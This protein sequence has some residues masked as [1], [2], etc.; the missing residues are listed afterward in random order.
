MLDPYGGSGVTLIEAMMLDRKA[1]HIDLNPLSVFLVE[2]LTAP[3][4]VTDL[5]EAF[6]R[7]CNSFEKKRPKSE[8]QIKAALEKYWYPKGIPLTKDAD[9]ETIEELFTDQQLAGLALLRNLIMKEK[10]ENIKNSLLLSFSSTVTKINRTYHSSSSRGENA[11]NA[12]AFA[13]YRYRMA[14]EEVRLLTLESFKIKFKKLV[15]AKKDISSKINRETIANATIVRGDATDLSDIADQ[16]IDYIYTDPPYGSKIAYLDLSTMWNAWLGFE[17]TAEDYQKEAIEGGSLNKSSDE[18]GDLLSK[19]IEEMFRVLKFDRWMSFVFAHK[20]PQY[21]HLIVETAEKAGFEYAGAV[22][23]SNGQ[24]SFKKR[25]NPFSVLSGQLVINFKKARN[26]QTIQKVRLGSE[27]YDLIIETIESVIAQDDGATLEQINDELILKGLELGFLDVLSKEYKDLTPILL[28]HFDY[29]EETD[30]FHIHVDKKFK[31][32]IPLDLRIRY[33]LLSYL[34][35][36][37]KERIFPTTDEI[38]LDIMPLLKNGITP[39]NQTILKVLGRIGEHHG[40]ERWK[41]KKTGQASL[42]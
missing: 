33:F 17:I 16:S 10:N 41:I 38:I 5:T 6:D 8:K 18:Y 37:E 4:S 2:A 7:V 23:Q 24:T 19:S 14:K 31:T 20:D 1:I 40:D 32:N 13:Y 3:V 29:H 30:T 12:A 26:Q 42:F 22:K 35:R 28:D 34:R 36:K 15:S 27:I 25:Q 39:E 9:V 11:G 21:W